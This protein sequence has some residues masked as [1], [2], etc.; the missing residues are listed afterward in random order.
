MH[1]SDTSGAS[2]TSDTLIVLGIDPGTR[3]IG[4]GILESEK[5]KSELITYGVISTNPQKT[6]AENLVE[7]EKKLSRLITTH[8]PAL[9]V[10]EKIFFS[11]NVKTAMAVS[12]ARGIIL[13][14]LA[15]HDVPIQELTPNEVKERVTGDGAADKRQIQ[16]MVRI[17]LDLEEAP[18]PDDAADALALAL[19]ASLAPN[20]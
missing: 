20:Y 16:K 17:I 10:V 7:L 14:T 9:A 1:S 5:S 19:S 2:D 3:I 6:Q 18:K 8:H 15:N 4:Y 13:L 11:K 12:E